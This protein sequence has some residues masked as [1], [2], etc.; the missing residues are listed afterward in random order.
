[1]LSTSLVVLCF[2]QGL[3]NP[4]GFPV[5]FLFFCFI[6]LFLQICPLITEVKNI[7]RDLGL[8]P[9]RLLPK[10]IYLTGCV[11][12]CCIVGDNHG[13]YVYAIIPQTDDWSNIPSVVACTLSATTGFLN[14]SRSNFSFGLVGFLAFLIRIWKVSITSSMSALG[15]LLALWVLP[16]DR[17]V[18]LQR[19]TQFDCVAFCLGCIMFIC[20]A[21]G[22]CQY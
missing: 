12:H 11:S 3:L 2:L 22:I 17:S 4:L 1:M 20:G 10:C 19:C 6:L 15:K 9:A 18:S 13:I 21:K 7:S 8:F 14:F 16:P 5:F